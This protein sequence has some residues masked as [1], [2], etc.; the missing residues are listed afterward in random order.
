MFKLDNHNFDH[1]RFGQFSSRDNRSWLM[2]GFITKTWF[3]NVGFWFKITDNRSVTFQ[4]KQHW[5]SRWETECRGFNHTIALKPRFHF[6]SES[7]S[8][9]MFLQGW[10]IEEQLLESERL[11]RFLRFKRSRH[12][13][14]QSPPSHA[15]TTP[16]CT[17]HCT[18]CTYYTN[19]A[20]RILHIW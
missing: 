8:R 10:L 15:L 9:E 11:R 7:I 18:Y 13:R 6:S 12:P 19:C 20:L 4:T 2:R 5:S 14:Q 17:A 1:W 3:R 16:H